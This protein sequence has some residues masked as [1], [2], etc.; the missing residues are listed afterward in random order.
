M[1]ILEF[2]SSPSILLPP[3]MDTSVNKEKVNTR[4]R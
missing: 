1:L 4:E 3:S 2:G